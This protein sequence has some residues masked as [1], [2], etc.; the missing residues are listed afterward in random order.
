[1]AKEIKI[2]TVAKHD[3][4]E[5]NTVIQRYGKYYRITRIVPEIRNRVHTGYYEVYGVEV[6]VQ[7]R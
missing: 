7:I 5:I 4:Y 1:M 6:I 3:K 2:E